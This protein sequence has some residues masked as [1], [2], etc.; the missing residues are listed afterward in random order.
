MSMH[1]NFAE[2]RMVSLVREGNIS[3]WYDNWDGT[4]VSVNGEDG[5]LKDIS[6]NRAWNGVGWNLDVVL[7]SFLGYL[8]S[9]LLHKSLYFFEGEDRMART[10]TT[11]VK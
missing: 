8:V 7:Q 3:L 9:T 10:E 5:P 11:N 6:L 4:G 2:S 1:R